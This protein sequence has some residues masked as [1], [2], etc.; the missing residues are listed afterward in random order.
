MGLTYSLIEPPITCNGLV[1]FHSFYLKPCQQT[2]DTCNMQVAPADDFGYSN[3]VTTYH[4]YCN[5]RYLITVLSTLVFLGA[6]L[7][8][9]IACYFSVR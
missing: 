5:R 2:H 4:L 1:L 8:G 6:L 9:S 7:G 3:I